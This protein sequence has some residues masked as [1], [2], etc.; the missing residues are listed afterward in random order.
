[1][2]KST[3]STTSSRRKITGKK[4][5]AGHRRFLTIG[6][7][8]GALLLTLL[9][10]RQ[11]QILLQDAAMKKDCLTNTKSGSGKNGQENTSNTDGNVKIGKINSDETTDTRITVNGKQQNKSKNKTKTS[12]DQT[13]DYQSGQDI[14]TGGKVGGSNKTQIKI[15]KNGIDQTIDKSGT[16]GNITNTTKKSPKNKTA[17]KDCA[18]KNNTSKKTKS[19][20][21]KSGSK[22][23]DKSGKNVS[24]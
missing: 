11:Q 20:A 4:P 23:T 10:L 19:S 13:N 21:K 3:K 16:D 5:T 7:I 1:M 6:I 9:A 8:L 17:L 12:A 22:A 2:K 18:G 14:N 15:N 24:K